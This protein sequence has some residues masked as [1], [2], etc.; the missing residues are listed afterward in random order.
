LTPAVI[1]SLLREGAL[2]DDLGPTGFDPQT[3]MGLINAAKAVNAAVTTTGGGG[4]LP[5]RLSASPAA[6]NFGATRTELEVT[7]NN[8]GGGELSIGQP[9]E[10]SGGWLSVA[11]LSDAADR[12]AQRL[13]LRLRVDR[14]ALAEG[15]YDAQVVV[16]SSANTVTVGVLIRVINLP[17]AE[18]GQQYVLLLDP[19]N[20]DTAFEGVGQ[21]QSD[22]SY[23]FRID[24][25]AA[26]TY[27]LI[28]GSDPDNDGFICDRAESCG[29]FRS[30]SDAQLIRVEGPDISDL[31]FI[32]GYASDISLSSLG[33]AANTPQAQPRFRRIE[34]RAAPRQVVRD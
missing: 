14:S 21:P 22:G 15:S 12:A 24:D 4:A 17:D 27:L 25:V 7:L 11:D 28:S 3:G 19:E 16:P 23:S 8:V 30:T 31:E 2:T 13:R 5:P 20:F 10:N 34:G 29:I 33:G 18:I 1:Q 9:R 32:S 26:G 6:V